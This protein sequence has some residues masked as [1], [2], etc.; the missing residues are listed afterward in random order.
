M[1]TGSAGVAERYSSEMAELLIPDPEDAE[2]LA[3]RII[4]WRRAPAMWKE[5]VHPVANELR[6][7]TWDAM[8]REIVQI[9]DE[10]TS[11]TIDGG[12]SQ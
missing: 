5:R 3:A 7:R 8:S 9:A 1:V 6:R 10:S 4:S 2:G 12:A 11:R